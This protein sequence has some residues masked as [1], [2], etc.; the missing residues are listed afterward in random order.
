MCW[1]W[2]SHLMMELNLSNYLFK[3]FWWDSRWL[4]FGYEH[5]GVITQAPYVTEVERPKCYHYCN[6]SGFAIIVLAECDINTC[7]ICASCDYSGSTK[8]IIAWQDCNLFHLLEVEKLLP[9]KYYFIGEKDFF[10]THH[11]LC[12]DQGRQWGIQWNIGVRKWWT[13]IPFMR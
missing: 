4:H 6:N 11:F 1:Q 2:V 12:E 13:N 8:G 9:Q 5:V 7:F 10:T 3:P